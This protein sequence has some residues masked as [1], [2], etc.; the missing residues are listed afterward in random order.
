MKTFTAI[1]IPIV[2]EILGKKSE[3]DEVVGQKMP[4]ESETVIF[5]AIFWEM[6][7]EA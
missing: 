3:K 6:S 1:N 4:I 2:C 7:L 5:K